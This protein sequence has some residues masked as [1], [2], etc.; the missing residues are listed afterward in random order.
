MRR[1]VNVDADCVIVDL[2]PEYFRIF[3]EMHGTNFSEE[4][5]TDFDFTKCVATVEQNNA[6]WKRIAETPGFVRDLPW[7]HEARQGLAELRQWADV[8]CVTSPTLEGTWIQERTAWLM[9]EAG[10][11]KNQIIFASDK[12]AHH[13]D[14]F[15]DDHACH[16]H[17]WSDYWLTRG[18]PLPVGVLKDRPCNRGDHSFYRVG[19]LLEAS[20]L[21]RAV[22]SDTGDFI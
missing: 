18:F 9:E 7:C 10:F 2:I 16:L 21:L 13:A 8:V 5:M 20:T 3:N 22:F 14:A 11:T 6:V 4:C 12:S 1:R 19:S 17:A 15:V